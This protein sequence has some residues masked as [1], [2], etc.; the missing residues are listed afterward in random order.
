N[1][2]RGRT[3]VTVTS[4]QE[5]TQ[6]ITFLG[7]GTVKGVVKTAGGATV[8]D[9][10][11]SFASTSIFGTTTTTRTSGSNG[12]FQF[13]GVFVGSYRPETP[14]AATCEK[15]TA[16]GSRGTTP[17]TVHG[18]LT[19]SP[20][21]SLEGYVRRSDNATVP[22]ATVFIGGTSTTTDTNGHFAFD[23]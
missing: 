16:P 22:N 3:A 2:N 5:A 1:G 14:R 21:G 23:F 19:M 12:E 11:L 9:A 13:D 6:D 4:G 15:G 8:P 10:A 17:Q 18:I 7:R 20:I